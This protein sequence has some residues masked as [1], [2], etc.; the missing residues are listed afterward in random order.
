MEVA[1][2]QTISLLFLTVAHVKQQPE[3]DNKTS[4]TAMLFT[5][6]CSFWAYFNKNYLSC[7]QALPHSV[8]GSQLCW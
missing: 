4:K 8:L 2:E 3:N 6:H 5:I 1:N 7:G